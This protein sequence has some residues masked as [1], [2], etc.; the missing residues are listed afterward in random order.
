ML[1]RR[2]ELTETTDPQLVI[3]DAK[4]ALAGTN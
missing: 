1:V 2:G 4:P 3:R